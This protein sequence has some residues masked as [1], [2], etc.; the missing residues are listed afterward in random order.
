MLRHDLLVAN[1]LRK[2]YLPLSDSPDATRT[3]HA[4]AVAVA[5]ADSKEH[6]IID[7]PAVGT[8][9]FPFVRTLS[10]MCALKVGDGM[11]G[12]A[13]LFEDYSLCREIVV[14][15]NRPQSMM[16]SDSESTQ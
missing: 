3:R 13:C 5:V 1:S 11:C 2:C 14:S 4:F 8:K 10:E 6:Q 15:P 7:V 16:Q 9:Q 12:C